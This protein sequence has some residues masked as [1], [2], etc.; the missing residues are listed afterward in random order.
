MA[1]VCECIIETRGRTITATVFWI[2][3][4]GR[5]SAIA[6]LC[7]KILICLSENLIRTIIDNNGG[8]EI[9]ALFPEFI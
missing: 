6:F 9:N 8:K 7:T 3:K 5:N 2:N 1:N 4:P